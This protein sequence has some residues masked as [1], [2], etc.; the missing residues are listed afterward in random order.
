[1]ELWEVDRANPERIRH[2]RWFASSDLDFTDNHVEHVFG[3]DALVSKEGLPFD[4]HSSVLANATVKNNHTGDDWMLG[5]MKR[6]PVIQMTSAQETLVTV[7]Y[8]FDSWSKL[9]YSQ[10]WS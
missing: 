3:F 6:P 2:R 9:I 4:F 8:L 10:V 5:W 1:M 7:D